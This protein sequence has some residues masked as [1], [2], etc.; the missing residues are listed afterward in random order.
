MLINLLKL[1]IQ[2]FIN[3]IAKCR[4]YDNLSLQ[5]FAL[6]NIQNHKIKSGLLLWKT[7]RTC[8]AH[9][10]K[11]VSALDFRLH[12]SSQYIVFKFSLYPA[13]R[14]KNEEWLYWNAITKAPVMSSIF[15]PIF[16][17]TWSTTVFI[18]ICEIQSLM[19][20]TFDS[21]VMVSSNSLTVCFPF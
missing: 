7:Y 17:K 8:F 10:K 16:F 21:F 5:Y 13:E 9:D 18:S 19:L 15:I 2:D 11:E 12:S 6:N 1:A 3:D 20:Q 4:E 14:C